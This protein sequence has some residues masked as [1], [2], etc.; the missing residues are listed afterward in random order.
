MTVLFLHRRGDSFIWP[1]PPDPSD[2]KPIPKVFAFA[3]VNCEPKNI[4]L[5]SVDNVKQ[6]DK[7]YV[8]FQETYMI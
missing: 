3:K 7:L 6:I 2:G 1:Q 5:W 4:R 8:S